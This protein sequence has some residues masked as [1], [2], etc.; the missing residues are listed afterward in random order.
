ME[1]YFFKMKT[2]KRLVALMPI[3]AAVCKE[4][5]GNDVDLET[6]HET[7]KANGN[8]SRD[9]LK[10]IKAKLELLLAGRDDK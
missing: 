3:K 6:L 10:D 9:E 2:L 8:A 5:Y 7:V 1:M 4:G